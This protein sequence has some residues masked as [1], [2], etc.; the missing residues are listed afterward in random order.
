MR[1]RTARLAIGA[2]AWIALAA[3]AFSAIRSERQI[4]TRNLGLQVFDQ[5]ARDASDGVSDLRMAQQAYVAL[6]QGVVFWMPKV[7][8]TLDATA[9]TIQ[10]LGQVAT[11][12]GA[13]SALDEA[14]ASLAEFAEIDKRAREFLASGQPFMAGDVIFAE[15]HRTAA[16]A[17]EQIDHRESLP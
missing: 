13:R 3:G 2:V 12:V 5:H 14:A 16:S 9:K 10:A 7:T 11:S 15:G 6:G 1:S 4:A 8:Q 17:I